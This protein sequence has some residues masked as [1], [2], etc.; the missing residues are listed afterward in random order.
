MKLC[1][2][3]KETKSS[4]SF[5]K[6][7]NLKS[8]LE[9][10]CKTCRSANHKKSYG[11]NLFN[12]IFRLKKSECKKKKIPFDLDEEYL[13]E[14]WTDYCPIFGVKLRINDKTHPDQYTLDRV[15]PSLGYIKGNVKFISFRANRIK[16]DATA[17]ELEKIANWIR[18][19]KE[20]STT[21][22]QGSTAK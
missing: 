8:G 4:D 7:S 13:K 21:I 18:L 12:W 9:T 20:S 2:Q 16:Y 6:N 11:K 14:I 22:P 1:P 5:H 17:D 3:C 10:Y 19:V 15:D